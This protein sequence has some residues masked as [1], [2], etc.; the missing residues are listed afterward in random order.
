MATPHDVYN[1]CKLVAVLLIIPVVKTSTVFYTGYS[2]NG[3]E[4]FLGFLPHFSVS[5]SL[6]MT[7]T[8]ST[9]VYYHIEAP[10]IDFCRNG[11]IIPNTQNIV[12]LPKNLTG[13][14]HTF[15]D[16]VRDKIPKAIHLKTSSDKVTVI[17]QSNAQKTID[18]FLAVPLRN[19]CLSEYVYYPFSVATRA[20]ADA[21]I[22]IIG[23]EDMTKSDY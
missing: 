15:P 8:E 14:S 16:S 11:I 13:R 17:G 19:L 9:P 3:A 18:T 6:I 12:D 20:K 2:S 10:G 5:P 1:F 22:A 7:T 21:S 4:Y 23:T